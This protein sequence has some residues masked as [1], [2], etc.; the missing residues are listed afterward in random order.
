MSGTD[1]DLGCPHPRSTQTRGV[2]SIDE[3][4]NHPGHPRNAELTPPNREQLKS[5]GGICNQIWL[6]MLDTIG[7]HD[8]DK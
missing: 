5:D 6:K 8:T 2:G 3:P 7:D 1:E 4:E